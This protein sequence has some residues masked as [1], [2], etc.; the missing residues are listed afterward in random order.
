[1][2]VIMTHSDTPITSVLSIGAH[3]D[4]L[5]VWAFATE[6]GYAAQGAQVHRLILTAGGLGSNDPSAHPAQVAAARKH[7]EHTAAGSSHV[8][9]VSFTD[10][11]DCDLADSTPVRETI[12]RHIRELRPQVVIC[13]HPEDW[14]HGNLGLNH[15]DHRA[16]GAAALAAVF[17]LARNRHSFPD[18]ARDGL[19]PHSVST[20]LMI[21][22]VTYNHTVDASGHQAAKALAIKSHG[23]QTGLIDFAEL[24]EKE[25]G[26]VE[27]FMRINQPF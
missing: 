10:F 2:K 3:P 15:P 6:A 1:M 9:S 24:R 17:P 8:A 11:L 22:P 21:S 12:V 25:L 7:E 19:Q 16:S 14:H 26:P 23:S 13:W 27:T 18:H 5:D 4:D 20:V